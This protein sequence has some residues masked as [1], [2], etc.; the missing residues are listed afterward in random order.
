MMDQQTKESCH[1]GGVTDP[2][3]HQKCKHL[4]QNGGMKEYSSNPQYSLGLLLML[5]CKFSK[6]NLTQVKRLRDQI[7]GDK[8]A[9]QEMQGS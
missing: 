4:L 8:C 2:D 5:P 3:Y 6:H 9:N 1:T 7:P